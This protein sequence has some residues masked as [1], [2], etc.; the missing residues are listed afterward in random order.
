MQS[1]FNKQNGVTLS[2]SLIALGLIGAI[3]ATTVPGFT[4]NMKK[5]EQEVRKSAVE[6]TIAEIIKTADGENGTLPDHYGPALVMEKMSEVSLI[7]SFDNVNASTGKIRVSPA[8]AVTENLVGETPTRGVVKSVNSLKM[9]SE[10]PTS[11]P[12]TETEAPKYYNCP[13]A[14]AG[15][16]GSQKMYK[17][18]N[19]A[20][21]TAVPDQWGA[22]G[23]AKICLL[24]KG[25]NT[26][27][28]EVVMM[29]L[30]R[31]GELKSS[32]SQVS[33][34]GTEA[35]RNT[36]TPTYTAPTAGTT[37]T[38]VN[39]PSIYNARVVSSLDGSTP[40]TNATGTY[41]CGSGASATSGPASVSSGGVLSF[42][43]PAN[44]SCTLTLSASG[45]QNRTVNL[46]TTPGSSYDWLTMQALTGTTLPTTTAPPKSVTVTNPTLTSPPVTVAP[47]TT[48]TQPTQNVSNFLSPATP[49]CVLYNSFS[50]LPSSLPTVDAFINFGVSGGTMPFLGCSGTGTVY[51]INT[52]RLTITS[53]ASHLF[54]GE[55]MVYQLIYQFTPGT[56]LTNYPSIT[57]WTGAPLPVA[58][59]TPAPTTGG[60][61]PTQT[62]LA[63]RDE[64]R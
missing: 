48:M 25:E 54:T 11:G 6:N 8:T 15:N 35:V 10:E 16:F 1:F 41:S 60:T 21:I 2:E 53:G 30:D 27:E 4:K 36:Q 33:T 50:G 17:L 23:K 39:T 32:V 59:Q 26:T 56:I 18:K 9:I 14:I 61:K 55:S 40:L 22:D 29:E 3:A 57:A 44:T 49:Y 34:T 62:A 46:Y 28:S 52:G 20:I 63:D 7:T 19:G 38:A 64:G 13:T 31:G 12:V 47:P 45:Y 43:L 24:P 42:T 5:R 51:D 58:S 37:N